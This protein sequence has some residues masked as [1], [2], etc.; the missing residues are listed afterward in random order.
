LAIFAGSFTLEAVEAICTLEA[1]GQEARQPRH[2]PSV[3]PTLHRLSRLVDKSLVMVEIEEEGEARYRL[4]ETIR[5][6]GADQLWLSHEEVALRQRH[7]SWFTQ[8]TEQAEPELLRAQQMV[9]LTRLERD[10]A[11][12][13]SALRWAVEGYPV[14]I[15][16]GLRLGGALW[17]FWDL[18]GYIAEG[19]EQ[20]G[21][22]LALPGAKQYSEAYAK[23]RFSAGMLALYQ[24]DS[25]R[26][27]TFLE[28]SRA[29]WQQLQHKADLALSLQ[30][31]GF[32]AHRLGRPDLA[33]TRYE[34][35]LVLWR[36]LEEPWGLAETF[37]LLGNLAY[38][39]KDGK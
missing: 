28:E 35:S 37:G 10:Y 17:R 22:L 8:L 2:Y 19:R 5:R 27:I 18:R 9:W 33:R 21:Q 34:E 39:E 38:W 16:A 25:E 12:L 1:W 3:I 23:A 11:N 14:D 7:L 26:A 30:H 20:L 15:E 29:L 32:I 36:A 31:L 6:Y 13:S 24:M 4:L